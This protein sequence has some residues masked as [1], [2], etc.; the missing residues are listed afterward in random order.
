MKDAKL[1]QR[2]LV[3]GDFHA[4][5]QH[6]DAVK[7]LDAVRKKFKPTRIIQLGD[8]CFDSE[9]QILTPAGWKYFKDLVDTDL[10]AQYHANGEISYVEPIRLIKKKY[11]GDMITRQ[12]GNFYSRTTANHKV[13]LQDKYGKLHATLAGDTSRA[14]F[15]IPRSGLLNEPGIDIRP[16]DIQLLAMF[17]ADFTFRSSGAIYGCLK[18]PRKIQRAVQLLEAANLQYTNNLDSRGYNSLHLIPQPGMQIFT[19]VFNHETILKF[20]PAQL[21]LFLSEVFLWD[22]YIDPT[23]NRKIYCSNIKSNVEIVQTVAHLLGFECSIRACK[24][25]GYKDVYQASVLFGKSRTTNLHNRVIE[26]VVDEE[27]YCATVPTGMLLVRQRDSISVSGNC[28]LHALSYHE[29]D[30]DLDAPSQELEKAIKELKPLY[31]MFPKVD[32]LESNH[33]SLVLRKGKTAGLPAKVFKSYNE[34]LDAPKGWTWHYEMIIPTA[35]SDIYFHHGK[36]SGIGKL[37][38]NMG[39]SSIQGH[40][41][42]KF[43]IAYWASP[44]GLYFDANAGCLVDRHSLAHAYMKNNVEKQMLGCMIIENGVPQLIPMIVNSKHRWIGKL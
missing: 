25:Q 40:F 18:R 17:S 29:H 26:S 23:R 41:H 35:L 1:N 5:Y 6:Q 31:D 13:I 44:R 27:V 34:I 28:D 14:H 36:S 42:T 43:Y 22:G 2:I 15:T 3:I 24:K 38:K 16:V 21:E 32:V 30:P 33:G 19:K 11:T 10:V 37:S 9:A 7:F 4:P 12:K 20:S 8:E 39:M